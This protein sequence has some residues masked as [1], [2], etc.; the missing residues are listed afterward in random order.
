LTNEIKLMDPP[1]ILA[2]R[3]SAVSFMTCHLRQL[4]T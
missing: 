3:A 4:S 2:D 1:F